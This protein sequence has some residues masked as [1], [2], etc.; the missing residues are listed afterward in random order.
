MK[1]LEKKR[2]DLVKLTQKNLNILIVILFLLILGISIFF[3][4]PALVGLAVFEDKAYSN[5][6]LGSFGNT[7]WNFSGNFLQLNFTDHTSN[8][9]MVING[10]YLS[11]I[12]DSNKILTT[13]NSINIT[14]GLPYQEELPKNQLDEK[15]T[16]LGSA[17]MTGNILLYHFNN[18]SSL[19]ENDTYI[20]DYSGMGNNATINGTIFNLT[21]SKYYGKTVEFNGINTSIIISNN[22]SFNKMSTGAVSFWLKTSSNVCQTVFSISNTSASNIFWFIRVGNN[23]C[24]TTIPNE[25]ILVSNFNV[26]GTGRN[27]NIAATTTAYPNG[28]TDDKWHHIVVSSNSTNNT[29]YLDGIQRSLTF[30]SGVH[31]HNMF[32]NISNANYVEIGSTITSNAPDVFFNGS[33]DEFAVWNRS[34][35]STEVLELYKRG[36]LHLNVSVR[37]CN[38]SACSGENFTQ[39]ISNHSSNLDSN[40]IIRNQYFQYRVEMRTENVSYTPELYN[41]TIDYTLPAAEAESTAAYAGGGGGSSAGAFGSNEISSQGESIQSF[42]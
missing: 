5:F 30:G 33:L 17:N 23:T 35:S 39:V 12:F 13:W 2:L 21:D 9:T 8:V 14:E 6:S 7:T 40:L 36:I 11:Q 18:D 10:T 32:I 19:G 42:N 22:T 26:G 31:D 25:V 16:L 3:L 37:S 20:Y 15:L 1:I 41:I 24:T 29:I 4:V 34:L 28:V 38:D 27:S